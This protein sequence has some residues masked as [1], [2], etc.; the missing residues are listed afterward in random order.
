MARY[1]GKVGFV[2]LKD[3]QVT[4]IVEEIAVEK[5]FF[6][7]VLEHSRRWQS[8]DTITD[9][10][11]LGNQISIT[12]TDYA[13]KHASAIKYCE[14]MGQ[15]WEVTDIRIKRPQ[16]VMTL[17]GVYNGTRPSDSA[18]GIAETCPKGMV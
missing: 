13:Y 1:H 6:G 4:G 12:A 14:F 18:G 8:S 11:R 15:M 16:I 7:K 9:D 2:L 3:N 5:P 10:L 17:G